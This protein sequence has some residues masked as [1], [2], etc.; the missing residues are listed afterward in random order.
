VTDV[1]DMTINLKGGELDRADLLKY[2]LHKDTP[3]VP[4]RLLDNQD[5][6]SLYLLQ[7]GLAGMRR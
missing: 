6:D 2:P 7:T 5:G 3:N 4:V 1:L